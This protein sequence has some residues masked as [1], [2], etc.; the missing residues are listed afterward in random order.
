ML[1]T[2][3][4]FSTSVEGAEKPAVAVL[5]FRVYAPGKLAYLKKGLQ[6]MFAER[7]EKK[8]LKIS[9]LAKT[10]SHALAYPS[11]NQKNAA[12]LGKALSSAFI[13]DGTVTQIGNRLSID[14]K[15]FDLKSRKPPSFIYGVAGSMK[16]IPNTVQQ[17][18]NSIY[19]R[20]SGVK[21]VGSVEVTGNKRIEK[22]AIL[23]VIQTKKGDR[24]NYDHLDQDLREVYKMGY[25][26]DV[27]IETEENP[28][29]VEVIFHVT[30]KPSIAKIVFKGNKKFKDSDLRKELGLKLYSILDETQVKQSVGRLKEFYRKK[31]Y[32]NAEIKERTV[33]L[34]NNEVSLEY[35][36]NEQNKVY[37]YKIEFVGNKAF[38]D[39]ELSGL[40]ET[41]K[42]GFFSWITDSGYL[43]KK[44][45]DFDVQKIGA[46]YHN[47]GYINAKVGTPEIE[48]T[49]GKGLKVIIEIEEGDQ[50]DVGKVSVQGDLIEPEA[51][52]MKIVQIDKEKAFN[53]ETLRKDMLAIRNLY[54]DKGY[55][56]ADVAPL[57]KED[58]KT[59]K[60][61]I[62]YKISTGPKVR[63]GRIEI[64]GNT[65]TRDKVIRREIKAIPGNYFSAE[66]IKKSMEN[67][68]RLGFFQK[69]SV[70]P[71][72]SADKKLMNL[73]FQVKE[74]PTGYFNFGVGYSSQDREF[75]SFQIAQNNLLGYGESLS[76]T[77]RLGGI[78]NQFDINF[79]EPWLL[80]K[81]ISLGV[82]LYKWMQEYSDY[83]IN[84]TGFATTLGFPLGIDEYTRGSVRYSL[85]NSDISNVASTAAYAI[86]DMI[87][88]NLTSSVT[89]GIM[90][91]SRDRPFN[92]HRGSV[93][94]I[95]YQYAGGVLGGDLYFD[96]Y[97]A[98]SAWYFPLPWNTVFLAQG[99]WGYV[100]KRPG[101]KLPVFEKF[102]IGG[103]DTVRGFDYGAIS[104]KDPVTGD[105]IG[106][107]K[108]MCYNFEYR[109]PLSKSQGVVGVVFYDAGNVFAK[110]QPV[111]FSGIR[112]SVG[113]G[114]RWY[115]PVGPLIMEY[116][117]NLHPRAG[118]P[119]GRWEFTVGGL[120]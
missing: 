12:E 109:F 82:D 44:K 112:D 73:D 5:P 49:R 33:P 98:R 72:A 81:P 32:Y 52:L 99:R 42:K 91:D 86:R 34:S 23:A 106:G 107:T 48:F 3:G 67:L 6:K 40:M 36:I 66:A 65:V 119:P 117:K 88:E 35:S 37:I 68:N 110:D 29:G 9:D 46:Y 7:L 4:P 116:G 90:R 27:K 64:T 76:A 21:L 26:K 94:S 60:V 105:L 96:K 97:L 54:A 111:T 69:V 89:L 2:F 11:L 93:N 8:G 115:S 108:M 10:D 95:S 100:V 77:T 74:R 101:G 92:T 13:V 118:E 104:P 103:I 78:S 1:L 83:T 20:V 25:F 85:D 15:L 71:K 102:A 50:Y 30:E 63:F 14:L 31:G 59:H 16:E 79:T 55:A 18:A 41:R 87:G 114:V 57:I 39:H 75:V 61:N 53:R 70:Q 28:N 113:A 43:E 58:T 120:F 51:K 47:H 62:A 56:F 19:N 38:S 84:S 17:L 80:G 22:D 45:L 24:L